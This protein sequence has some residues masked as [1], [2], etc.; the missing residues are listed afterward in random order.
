[1]NNPR[2]PG[3]RLTMSNDEELRERVRHVLKLLFSSIDQRR[4]GRELGVTQTQVSHTL[5]GARRPS[6]SLVKKLSEHPEVNPEWL[7][8]GIG[9]PLRGQSNE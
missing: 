8:D 6:P 3:R 5:T 9:K 1:M 2:K 4:A 7:I